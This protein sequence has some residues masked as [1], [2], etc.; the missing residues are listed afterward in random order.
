MIH[1]N[2]NKKNNYPHDRKLIVFDRSAFQKIHR[3][4]LLE[5][6]KKYNILCPQIFVMECLA[7]QNTDKKPLEE[8]EKDKKSLLEKLQLIE[9]PIVLKGSADISYEIITD[10]NFEYHIILTSDQIAKNCIRFAPITMER[11]EPEELISTYELLKN[12][13]KTDIKALEYVCKQG[14]KTITP[15]KID[16]NIKEYFQEVHNI[17]LSKKEIREAR[18]ANEG[19]LLTQTLGCAAIKAW[20][21]IEFKTLGDIISEFRAHFAL[22]NQESQKLKDILQ[23]GKALTVENYP[24]LSYPIYLYYL[25]FY[26]TG[27][28]QYKTE[29]FDQ[30]YA[31]DIRYLHY[32]NFCDVF[33]ANEKST[34]YI[35]GSLPFDD[36]RQTPVITVE[37]LKKRLN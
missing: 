26:I 2:Y 8:L 14:E 3:N 27:A 21:D 16:A 9:N 11:V 22:T 4:V 28:R 32:L 15:G 7:P 20:E 25:I 24:T 17:T 35:V 36:I 37:E 1:V 5:V 23:Y 12:R 6:N 33:V 13:L 34:P 29:H 30:S 31:R 19:M 18:R 10:H